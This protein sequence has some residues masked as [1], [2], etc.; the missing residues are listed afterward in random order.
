[1]RVTSKRS[2][3]GRALIYTTI[4]MAGEPL[5]E[6]EVAGGAVDRSYRAVA[7]RVKGVK[8]REPGAELPRAEDDLETASRDPPAALV[9]EQRRAGVEPLALAGL[10]RPEPGEL[11]D[12]GVGEEHGASPA[13]LGDLGAEPDPGSRRAIR[14]VH[15]ADV[16]PDDFG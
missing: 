4:C 2:D 10:V 16:E 15:V 3:T 8:A 9:A 7:R 13:S 12:E 11:G 6:E 5:G 1:M 14:E